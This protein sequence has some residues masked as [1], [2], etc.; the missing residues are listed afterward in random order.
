VPLTAETAAPKR[1]SGQFTIIV[2][3][4]VHGSVPFRTCWKHW[5]FSAIIDLI[6]G[7]GSA[8]PLFR[9]TTTISLTPVSRMNILR[10]PRYHLN[11]LETSAPGF[12]PTGQGSL[13]S[14]KSVSKILRECCGNSQQ[15]DNGR[16]QW[17]GHNQRGYFQ[18]APLS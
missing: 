1:L 10:L 16:F 13:R 18:R 3:C 8:S 7:Y 11:S 5:L 4:I 15:V 14:D 9:D 12:D 2:A 17:I 6:K